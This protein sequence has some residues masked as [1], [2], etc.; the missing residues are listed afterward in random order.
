MKVRSVVTISKWVDGSGYSYT[1]TLEDDII[2][3]VG[4]TVEDIIDNFDWSWWEFEDLPENEDLEIT[5]EYFRPD[6]DEREDILAEF[7][8]WQ[9]EIGK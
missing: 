1:E 8:I 9:S 5:V 7:S 6:D 2:E 4:E 3:L